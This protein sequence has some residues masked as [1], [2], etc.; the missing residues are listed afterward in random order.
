MG[1]DRADPR[2]ED[3]RDL[4]ADIAKAKPD[5]VYFGGGEESNAVQLWRDLHEANP[6]AL[7]IGQ[8]GCS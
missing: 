3:Y 5:A 2:A 4:A 1:A 8:T 6:N 7:L